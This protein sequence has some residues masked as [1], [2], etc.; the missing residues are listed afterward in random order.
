MSSKYV[1]LWNVND[2]IKPFTAAQVGYMYAIDVHRV[3]ICTVYGN[4]CK[5][6]I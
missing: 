3:K 6:V 1:Q 4:V 5:C 2:K